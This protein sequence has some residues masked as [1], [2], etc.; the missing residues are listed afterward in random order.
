M[1]YSPY[2]LKNHPEQRQ[3]GDIADIQIL[4]EET[5]SENHLEGIENVFEKNI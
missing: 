3:K 4:S 1:K 5:G 2:F